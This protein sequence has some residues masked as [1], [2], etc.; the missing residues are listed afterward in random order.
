M[1][2]RDVKSALLAAKCRWQQGKG[3]HEKWYC[4]EK[5]GKHMAVVTQ[6]RNISPGVIRDLITKLSC[7][8]EG[9]LQ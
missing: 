7:L 4:P 2:Y 6:A 5:C 9:W 8:P 3:D 1:K